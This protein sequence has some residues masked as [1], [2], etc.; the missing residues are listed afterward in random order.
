MSLGA[1]AKIFL[2]CWTSSQGYLQG[3]NLHLRVAW[4]IPRTLWTT[5]PPFLSTC[6]DHYLYSNIIPSLIHCSLLALYSSDSICY[7]SMIFKSRYRES[8]WKTKP[9]WCGRENAFLSWS[10]W[11]T[12][13]QKPVTH[14][15]LSNFSETRMHWEK[16]S[17]Q[18]RGT[19]LSL[20]A[21]SPPSRSRHLAHKES[22]A[23]AITE[24]AAICLLLVPCTVCTLQAGQEASCPCSGKVAGEGAY[25][26]WAEHPAGLTGWGLGLSLCAPLARAQ[27]G[28]MGTCPWTAC[29]LSGFFFAGMMCAIFKTGFW[30][31]F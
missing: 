5:Y 17:Q 9:G 30:F 16:F 28:P 22:S 21:Q 23:L 18:L 29:Q 1:Q 3:Q 31:C 2:A 10:L 13:H 15:L 6:L 14:P 11:E 7:L 4:H 19:T 27:V 26:V 8:P 25:H 12:S 20:G 24:P